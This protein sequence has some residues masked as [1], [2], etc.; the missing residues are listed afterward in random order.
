MDT[1]LKISLML[2]RYDKLLNA[3]QKMY[4]VPDAKMDVLRKLILDVQYLDE[5]E[6]P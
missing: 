2:I 4:E 3:I 6:T 1:K 5:I